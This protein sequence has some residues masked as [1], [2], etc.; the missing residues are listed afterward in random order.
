MNA[1]ETL[2]EAARRAKVGRL[3]L[4]AIRHERAGACM[5]L[6]T[7]LGLTVDVET[8]PAEPAVMKVAPVAAV[9]TVPSPTETKPAPASSLGKTVSSLHEKSQRALLD[10]SPAERAAV[11][12]R[13]GLVDDVPASPVIHLAPTV[14]V[15]NAMSTLAGDLHPAV[16]ELAAAGIRDDLEEITAGM[17]D[18]GGHRANAAR[19]LEESAAEQVA[20]AVQEM[21]AEKAAE[22]AEAATAATA[23]EELTP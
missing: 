2:I 3:L 16:A 1:K 9:A 21:A 11:V 15:T 23:A 22:A 4:N 17:P 20:E 18:P 7:E 12:E 10:L 5:R 6:A 14:F 19:E 13:L 8:S